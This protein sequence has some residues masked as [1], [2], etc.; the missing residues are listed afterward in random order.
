MKKKNQMLKLS[1]F[2]RTSKGRK[3]QLHD[4]ASQ[5]DVLSLLMQEK[6]GILLKIIRQNCGLVLSRFAEKFAPMH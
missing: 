1:C 4:E 3:L 6:K 2:L 5:R